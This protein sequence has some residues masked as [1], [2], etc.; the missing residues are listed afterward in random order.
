M[1]ILLCHS[2]LKREIKPIFENFSKED[3]KK[4][5]LKVAD[6]LG[7]EIKGSFI[8]ATKL[9]KVYMTGSKSAARMLVLVYVNKD[10]YLPVVARLK[11]DK[12]VGANLG[13]GNKEFQDILEQNLNLIMQDL[14][15]R[16]F[17]EL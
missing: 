5:V 14:E 16:N 12:I 10:Y 7:N 13:K 8:P 9:I 6:G 17:E 11:K 4:Y 2:I 1:K 3:I 15:K